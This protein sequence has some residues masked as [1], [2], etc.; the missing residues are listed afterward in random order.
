MGRSTAS[1]SVRRV[2]RG[3]LTAI[4]ATALVVLG[5]AVTAPR[6]SAAAAAVPL[7]TGSNAYGQL[8]APGVSSRTKPGPVSVP[9]AVMIASGRDHAYAID[10]SGALWAWGLNDKGQKDK[11]V[12]IIEKYLQAF[13][14]MNFPYDWNTMQMLNVMIQAGGYEKAKPHLERPANETPPPPAFTNGLRPSSALRASA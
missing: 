13:P 1:T 11:A 6:T 12:A 2:H 3:S 7:S 5:V 14:E 8:G 9:G 4:L 10:E